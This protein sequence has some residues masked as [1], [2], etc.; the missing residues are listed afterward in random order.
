MRGGRRQHTRPARRLSACPAA[1]ERCAVSDRRPGRNRADDG[2]F[3]K[4]REAGLQ[5]DAVGFIG[6]LRLF[7]WPQPIKAM[8]KRERSRRVC[9]HNIAAAEA[10]I[11]RSGTMPCRSNS[12]SAEASA[13]SKV[14]SWCSLPGESI[15][16][17]EERC[18]KMPAISSSGN[19]QIVFDGVGQLVRLEA[20]AGSSRY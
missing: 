1:R 20:L 8:P 12:G 4:V 14:S 13:R 10:A 11:W 15:S 5:I 6:S 3:R 18:E 16:S 9:G 2:D 19:V 17:A 7:G